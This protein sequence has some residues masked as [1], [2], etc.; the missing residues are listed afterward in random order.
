MAVARINLETMAATVIGDVAY[1]VVRHSGLV[2]LPDGRFLVVG[3]NDHESPG[4]LSVLDPDTGEVTLLLTVDRE[5]GGEQIVWIPAYLG[6]T[7]TATSVDGVASFPDVWA[8]AAGEDYVV[9]AAASGHYPDDT[10]PFAVRDD[11]ERYLVFTEPPV[12][13]LVGRTMARVS[14]EMRDSLDRPVVRNGVPVT[15]SLVADA[16]NVLHAHGCAGSPPDA[17]CTSSVELI[18]GDTPQRVE[19]IVSAL[20]DVKLTALAYNAVDG[21]VYGREDIGADLVTIDPASGEVAVRAS[22]MLVNSARAFAFRDGVLYAGGAANAT[23]YT[24]DLDTG[25]ETSQGGLSVVGGGVFLGMRGFEY[26]TA[27][28]RF[29]ALAQIG[30]QVQLATVDVDALTLTPVAGVQEAGVNFTGLTV[31]PDG[32]L[33]AVAGEGSDEPGTL[34]TLDR[35]T[36][37][38]TRL[39]GPASSASGGEQITAVPAP[40]LG[41]STVATNWNGAARFED[42]EVPAA[43]VGFTLE[44]AAPGWNPGTSP[45]FDVQDDSDRYLGFFT[46]PS[47]SVYPD[48]FDPNV[49]VI[50]YNSWGEAI[51]VRGTEVTLAIENNPGAQLYQ[52]YGCGSG[53]PA[54][55]SALLSFVEPT[56]PDRGGVIPASLS[57]R[58]ITAMAY[59]ATDGLLYARDHRAQALLQ[60]DPRSGETVEVAAGTLS[61]VTRAMAAFDGVL[62]A[63]TRDTSEVYTIDAA[64]GV[65][66]GFQTISVTDGRSLIFVYGGCPGPSPMT[67]YVLAALEA[68]AGGDETLLG[69]LDLNTLE[70]TPMGVYGGNEPYLSGLAALPNG[71]LIAVGGLDAGYPGGLY[72]LDPVTGAVA[73]LAE[74][75]HTST[76]AEQIVVTPALLTGTATREVTGSIATF[77]SLRVKAV[78]AAYTL[79]AMAE[80]F[81]DAISAPFNVVAP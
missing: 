35:S 50:L 60:I 73:L 61:T 56:I 22:G 32:R 34:Y 28:G 75:E 12:D 30:M 25:A 11:S 67:M 80:G 65:E 71:T 6:G 16:A 41:T 58:Q 14:V 13:A 53:S 77:Y 55:C 17:G 46:Q 81:A 44:A 4:S 64:T 69:Y 45:A 79:R 37:A 31:L 8:T 59:R 72:S 68:S 38:A 33:V 23:L 5:T 42:L 26:E 48:A 49:Q 10:A 57:N 20:E 2:W 74:A 21:L 39:L 3:G 66:G 78:G 47:D 70:L 52:A 9:S 54:T 40:L 43:G 76:G 63:L 7:R 1:G 29:W 27:T 15:V 36:G 24:V 19:T 62:Y 18:D 51:G